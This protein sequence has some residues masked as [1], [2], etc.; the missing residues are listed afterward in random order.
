MVDSKEQVVIKRANRSYKLI[1]VSDDDMLVDIPK[2]YR[3]DPYDISPS[4]DIFWADK[5]NVDEI[6]RR[7][8]KNEEPSTTFKNIEEIKS[9]LKDL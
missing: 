2:E 3:C 6:K 1:P 8:G 5:R 4:G 9:F 7:I